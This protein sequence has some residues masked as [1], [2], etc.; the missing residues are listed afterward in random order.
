MQ[1]SEQ[2]TRLLY[3][4][5]VEVVV[6]QYPAKPA[7]W[8]TFSTRITTLRFPTKGHRWVGGLIEAEP[9]DHQEGQQAEQI[10][11]GV[12]YVRQLA[13]SRKSR[14]LSRHAREIE[15]ANGLN[16]F[17]ADSAR[18]GQVFTEEAV[19]RRIKTFAGK[20]Q[21]GRL[22]AGNAQFFANGFTEYE[23]PYPGF[24]YDGKPLFA[25]SGNAHPFKGHTATGSQGVNLLPS[26]PLTTDNYGTAFL[27]MT[28]TNAIDETGREIEIMPTHLIHGAALRPTVAQVLGSEFLPG[29]A[30]NDKNPWFGTIEPVNMAGYI[31]D[32]T[33]AWWLIEGNKAF[34][35]YDR[36]A[37]SVRTWHD[38]DLDMFHVEW[39]DEFG[40][41]ETDWR[42]VLGCNMNAS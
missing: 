7:A 41:T 33:S 22:S 27:Q 4:K 18:V 28:E 35:H 15:A 12:G 10:M 38:E 8:E 21:K 32:Q 3:D 1:T 19:R 36:G 24:I 31:R 30:N 29:S 14:R 9:R 17:I 5:N 23:D 39:T 26:T 37:P 40:M 42:Y 25:A 13:V 2:L 20:L 11:L 16:D 34:A 6:S